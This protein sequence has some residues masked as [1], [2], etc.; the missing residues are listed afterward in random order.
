MRTVVS[1][2]ELV[3]CRIGQVPATDGTP[4]PSD[5]R[6]ARRRSRQPIS[7][8]CPARLDAILD[9]MATTSIADVLHELADVVEM[10]ADIERT[11]TLRAVLS[12]AEELGAQIEERD[13]SVLIKFPHH[14]SAIALF[15]AVTSAD[16]DHTPRS[17]LAALE[18]RPAARGPSPPNGGLG[19]LPAEA[20]AMAIND[21]TLRRE[22]DE[23]VGRDPELAV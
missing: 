6:H 10:P 8:P 13:G 17:L 15:V 9:A 3:S 23:A 1:I 22:I 2:A 7:S 14:G 18:S 12:R 4:L 19:A 16:V 5:K 21:G 20:L 11:T